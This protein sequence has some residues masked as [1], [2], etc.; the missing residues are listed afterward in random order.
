MSEEA[1]YPKW[2]G[3]EAIEGQFEG[4]PD[5][6][7]AGFDTPPQQLPGSDTN[8]FGGYEESDFH[9]LGRTDPGLGNSL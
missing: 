3:T 1:K 5:E 2:D 8:R 6:P 9:N 4:G 7:Q